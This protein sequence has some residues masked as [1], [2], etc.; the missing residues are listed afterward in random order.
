MTEQEMHA[1][2][3]KYPVSCQMAN[4]EIFISAQGEVTPCCWTGAQLWKPFE[5]KGDN[6]IWKLIDNWEGHSSLPYTIKGNCYW[7]ILSEIRR[8]F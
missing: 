8:I 4:T 7:S 3:L 2:L 1:E 6:P 5:K